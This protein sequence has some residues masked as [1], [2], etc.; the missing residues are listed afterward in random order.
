MPLYPAGP[1]LLRRRLGSLEQPPMWL[2]P[3]KGERIPIRDGGAGGGFYF[4]TC[5]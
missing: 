1:P 5:L 3:H 4:F 2:R